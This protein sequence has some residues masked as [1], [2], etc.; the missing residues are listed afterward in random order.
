MIMSSRDRAVVGLVCGR[1][2]NERSNVHVIQ[3]DV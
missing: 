1:S 2:N 3:N